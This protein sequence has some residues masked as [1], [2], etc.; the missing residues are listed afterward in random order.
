MTNNFKTVYLLVK[1][2]WHSDV[3]DEL[4]IRVAYACDIVYNAKNLGIITEK[5]FKL[6]HEKMSAWEHDGDALFI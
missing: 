5:E 4:D 2:T 1:A 3:D 6:M